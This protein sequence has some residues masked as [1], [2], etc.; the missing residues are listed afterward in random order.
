MICMYSL[1]PIRVFYIKI[2]L[3]KERNSN[4]IK[5]AQTKLL[6]ISLSLC[7]IYLCCMYL[8]LLNISE[9]KNCYIYFSSCVYYLG[10]SCVYISGYKLC[11]FLHCY[12]L[13]GKFPL[14][15][16]ILIPLLRSLFSYSLFSLI[17]FFAKC[18]GFY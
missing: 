2:S 4:N 18:L 6:V 12:K 9:L 14:S 5:L 1:M 8:F 11:K 3:E 13:Q 16:S 15:L 10:K 7:D 17:L